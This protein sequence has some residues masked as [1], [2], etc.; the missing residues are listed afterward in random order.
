MWVEP[1]YRAALND[2]AKP[3]EGEPT[4]TVTRTRKTASGKRATRGI[5][6]EDTLSFA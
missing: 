4:V 3:E 6:Y 5:K 1:Q 2:M